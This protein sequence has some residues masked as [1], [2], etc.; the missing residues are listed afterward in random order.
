MGILYQP[1][2][3]TGF[4]RIINKMVKSKLAD[5]PKRPMS[6]YFL[7]MNEVGRSD[8]KKKNPDASITEVKACGA[9]WQAIDG[10][11]KSKF[12]KKAEEA[13]KSYDK[14]YKTWLANGGEELLAQEKNA[15]KKGKGKAAPKKGKGSPKKAAKGK[16]KAESSEE[17][18]E[19]EE[20]AED[21]D[22]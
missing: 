16:K 17:E 1:F 7:W 9:A 22:Y 5:K 21:S 12:E 10:S 15:K 13:K 6:A 11:T 2:S 4:K 8:V 19:E 14:E 3:L 18:D 20:E